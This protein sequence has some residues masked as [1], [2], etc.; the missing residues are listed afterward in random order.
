MSELTLTIQASELAAALQELA[1]A[2][3]QSGTPQP[4]VPTAVAVPVPVPAAVPVASAPAYTLEQISR[5]GAALVDAGKLELLQA[6][7]GR[8]NVQ[9]ITQLRPEQYGAFAT[10]LRA[11]GGQPQEAPHAS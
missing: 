9:A 7:L 5:A 3:R 6:L 10:E 8:Y 1:A 2:I 11:L 4:A